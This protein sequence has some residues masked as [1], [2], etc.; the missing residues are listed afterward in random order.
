M[1]HAA[2]NRL[3]S[4]SSLRSQCATMRQK[5]F[6]WAL[7]HAGSIEE[8][9]DLGVA[10]HV[11]VVKR[12]DVG[13]HEGVDAVAQSLGRL[14]EREPASQPRRR[15][16]MAA[17]VDS[18]RRMADRRQR[19]VPRPNPVRLVRPRSRRC[20]KEELVVGDELSFINPRAHDVDEHRAGSARLA[21]RSS[22]PPA[23]RTRC[24][25]R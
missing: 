18:K 14:A 2:T 16:S 3:A 12:A 5:P 19:T 15:R 24:P 1:R 8:T 17:V 20:P 21:A 11:L 13:L 25:P 10:N 6:R 7:R 23:H 4:A 9:L 22:V